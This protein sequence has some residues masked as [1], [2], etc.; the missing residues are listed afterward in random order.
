VIERAMGT[1]VLCGPEFAFD[2]RKVIVCDGFRTLEEEN[3][4]VSTEPND[5]SGGSSG[6]SKSN[7]NKIS[8]RHNNHK[9]A[10]RNGIVNSEQAENYRQYK[11][12]LRQLCLDAESS[13]EPR[14]VFAN[15]QVVELDERHGYGFALRHVLRNCI[16]T[17]FVCVVQHDRTFMRPTPM[18]ATVQAMW[19]HTNVK[20]VGFSMRS[21]LMYRDIFLGKYGGGLHQQTQQDWNDMVLYLPEL[22]L[23]AVEFGPDSQST[24]GMEVNTDKLRQNI[25][26]LAETY[27]GSAQAGVARAVPPKSAAGASDAL[28]DNEALAQCQLSL[29]PTLYWY[30][31][32]HICETSHYR[33]F[34]F[35]PS[36]KMVTRG[37][38]IEDKLSPVLKRTVERLG[39]KDGH[40][41]FGC[42]LLDDHS[43]Y[44]FT[45]HI[46]GG[47]FISEEERQALLATQKAQKPAED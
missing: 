8:R 19:Y 45:G 44:F 20:Y 27:R 37:G 2:C 46:D 29:V 11:Q 23:P 30:D 33:D 10:M 4:T 13:S 25:A 41:R 1:F 5:S 14:S 42:Y 38:F 31:N 26:S 17:P 3:D 6:A 18:L 7:Q 22:C 12:R 21:N 47:S 9:Q 40:S 34:V 32:V 35:E 39:L 16:D 43:G 24:L 28:T 15:A 36:Y